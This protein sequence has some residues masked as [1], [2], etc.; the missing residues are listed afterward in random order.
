[1]DAADL[2][3]AIERCEPPADGFHHPSH[4]RVA[5]AYLASESS[6][7]EAAARMASTL[8][9]FAASVGQAEKYHHTITVFWIRCLAAERATRPGAT[10]EEVLADKP[11]LL[12][13]NLP[14]AF[15]SPERLF[16][17][18]ARAAWVEPDLR[19][20]KASGPSGPFL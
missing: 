4:L 17:A 1:M 5:W 11:A 12:D 16:S 15:Y 20:L 7:D 18:D 19:P 10:L 2:V 9:R 3:Q 14:L 6:P 8:R 13:K